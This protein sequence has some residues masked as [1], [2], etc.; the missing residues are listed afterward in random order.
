M[1]KFKTLETTFDLN[2]NLIYKECYGDDNSNGNEE[3]F[4]YDSNGN[5]IH[6]TSSKGEDIYYKYDNNN[7]NCIYKKF[8][9]FR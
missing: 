9:R 2:G 8:K 6:Y 3:K 7:N 4:E 1:K 5:L